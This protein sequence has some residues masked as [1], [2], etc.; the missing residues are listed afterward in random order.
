MARGHCGTRNAI[1]MIGQASHN[2]L[3]ISVTIEN[4][5]QSTAYPFLGKS[6]SQQLLANQVPG[7]GANGQSYLGS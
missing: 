6:L 3:I 2:R 1:L 7:Y 4:S 5:A